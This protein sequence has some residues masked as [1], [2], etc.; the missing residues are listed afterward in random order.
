[1][2]R[3][4]EQL[5]IHIDCMRD[6]A[7][8]ALARHRADPPRAWIWDTIDGTRYRIMRIPG[9]NFDFNPF[10][11]AAGPRTS[12]DVMAQQTIFVTGAGPSA[13]DAGWFVLN[14]SLDI[15]GGTGSSETLLDHRC[16]AAAPL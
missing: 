14:S 11:L 2:R 12:P 4:Q 9:P 13:A 10:D 16:E 15:D 3:S 8:A 7:T 6:G 5:H 1:M